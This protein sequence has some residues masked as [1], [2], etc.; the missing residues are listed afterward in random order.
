MDASSICGEIRNVYNDKVKSRPM[1]VS[2]KNEEKRDHVEKLYEICSKSNN[3]N[4]INLTT[5]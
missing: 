5:D 1:F 2:K 4:K 3:V